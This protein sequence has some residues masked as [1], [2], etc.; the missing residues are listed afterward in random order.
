MTVTTILRYGRRAL[1]N[2]A[3]SLTLFPEPYTPVPR[4]ETPAAPQKTIFEE[5]WNNVGRCMNDAIETLRTEGKLDG[6][7][8][9]SE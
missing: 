8:K 2:A 4:T 6:R 3:Y 7:T 1:R 5:A 9:Q